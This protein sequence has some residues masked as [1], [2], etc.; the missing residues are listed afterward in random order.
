M[1]T[2][3]DR[4]LFAAIDPSGVTQIVGWVIYAVLAAIAIWGAF[5]V[6]IVWMRVARQR[7]ANEKDQAEFLDQL[8]EPLG[9]GDFESAARMCAD[10]P[11]A[12]PQLALLALNHRHVDIVDGATKGR[13]SSAGG[14]SKNSLCCEEN[15]TAIQL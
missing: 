1:T 14:Y 4:I 9:R 15:R 6:A 2:F 5:C 7:F 12:T 13:Q 10:D 8:D 11:R 3:G